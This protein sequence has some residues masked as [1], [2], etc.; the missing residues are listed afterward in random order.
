MLM[1]YINRY[2]KN[3]K[4]SD[5]QVSFWGG[6][7]VLR[8]LELRL[9][10]LERELRYPLEIKSGHIRELI[11]HIPWNAILSKPVE[12]VTKDVEIVVKLKDVR[13]SSSQQASRL[14]SEDPTP[15]RDTAKADGSEQQGYL[16]AYTSRILNNL[17][18]HVQNLV[19]KV[20]EEES[21]MAMSF[22][23]QSLKFYMTDE[24]WMAS[25]V[26]TDY[27]EGD[28]TLNKVLEITDMVINL[29]PIESD[30]VH[31]QTQKEPFVIKCSFSCHMQS[32]YRGKK[33]VKKST[34]ILFDPLVF[35]ADENQFCL[36]LHLLDWLLAMY[37]SGKRLKGRD[38]GHAK[39]ESSQLTVQQS[40]PG[41]S[42]DSHGP[43]AVRPRG[44]TLPEDVLLA[45]TVGD[46]ERKSQR[47]EGGDGWGSWVW[48]F[49]AEEEGGQ[50]EGEKP[51][52]TNELAES[53]SFAIIAKSITV[54]LKV[55]MDHSN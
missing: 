21:D 6:D 28:Y 44:D 31:K 49:V 20:I 26:C 50:D 4:P 17:T 48:S 53:S 40:G 54:H 52:E 25:Y 22:N 47:A 45:G 30:R 3:I 9:D 42:S 51:R 38:D 7:A 14:G 19:V 36:F 34:C 8:N 10:V 5:L 27:C 24:H 16:Q 33:F 11:L 29:Q 18:F 32:Q 39:N 35:S 2:V 12:V 46:L 13:N 37:Y 43:S 41:P 15:S 23:I 1:G 55:S